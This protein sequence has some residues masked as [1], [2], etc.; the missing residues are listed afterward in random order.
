MIINIAGKLC[1]H[2]VGKCINIKKSIYVFS[3]E[4]KEKE[5]K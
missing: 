2:I 4:R 1:K 5:R 3:S